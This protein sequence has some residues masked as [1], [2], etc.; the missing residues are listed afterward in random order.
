MGTMG[1]Q[2]AGARIDWPLYSAQF[3]KISRE[4]LLKNICNRLLQANASVNLPVIEKY[5]NK[6]SRE[7][8]IKSVSI[9]LMSTPEYQ[10]C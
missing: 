6:S 10:L 3:D 5:G 8:F 7:E 9:R 1:R 2:F 4:D